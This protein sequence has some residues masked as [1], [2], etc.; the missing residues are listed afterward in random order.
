MHLSPTLFI[1]AFSLGL[2]GYGIWQAVQIDR[3]RLANAK[4]AEGNRDLSLEN[5]KLKHATRG[6][7]KRKT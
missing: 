1:A 5:E 7:F 6:Q 2:V 4:L 3:L